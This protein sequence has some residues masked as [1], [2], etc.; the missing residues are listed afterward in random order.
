V[1]YKKEHGNCDVKIRDKN[2]KKLGKWINNNREEYKKFLK[3][4]DA[5]AGGV[6]EKL[7]PK[8]AMDD[9]R[10]R[11]LEAIGFNWGGSE[12]Q[13]QGYDKAWDDML[14]AL[15]KYREDEG[16]CLV[17]SI[18]PDDP[19]LAAWVNHQR[20]QYRSYHDGTLRVAEKAGRRDNTKVV[21]KRL[22]ILE[23][24]GFVFEVKKSSWDEQ[25]ENLVIFKNAYGHFNV[26][27][28]FEFSSLGRWVQTQRS[29]V[30]RNVHVC[31]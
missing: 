12:A 13:E 28:H 26:S 4:K 1:E 24:L 7:L 2:N 8:T 25:L 9:E 18:Y 15:E 22:A 23:E 16:D 20:T 30:S 11:K 31:T 21:E 5:I 27:I 6:D 17:P 10:V 19:K 29:Q 3:R 14:K